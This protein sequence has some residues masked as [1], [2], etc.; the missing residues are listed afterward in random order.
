MP[1]QRREVG[2]HADQFLHEY[3]H[4]RLH[5]ARAELRHEQH[6]EQRQHAGRADHQR[7]AP[8]AGAPAMRAVGPDEALVHAAPHQEHGGE[9]DRRGAEERNAV[10]AGDV[11]Q[12]AADHRPHQRA[13]QLPGAE[14]AQRIAQPPLGHLARHQRH[15]G[16]GEAGE[17]AHQ[18]AG[19]EEL[20]DVLRDAHARGEQ[21]DRAARA[22]QHRLAAIAVGKPSPQRR[23][24]G[25]D[26]RGGAVQDAGPQGDPRIGGH[27]E[28][29]QEQRHDRAEEAERHGHDELDA[30]HRPQRHLPGRG[31]S[32]VER[33]VGGWRLA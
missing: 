20:P 17:H 27:A 10:A 31:G 33:L 26:E 14:Q 18:R 8:D 22:D 24:E 13:D 7:Q 28:F 23:G 12:H 30:H 29:R 19:G 2:P 11:G 21:R 6:E 1:A 9:G 15:R 16:G 32:V 4:Q 25:R 3:R 5:R